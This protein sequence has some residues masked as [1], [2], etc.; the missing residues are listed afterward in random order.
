M[1]PDGG[2]LEVHLTAAATALAL[3]GIVPSGTA[4]SDE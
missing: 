2:L 3:D 4:S 1:N